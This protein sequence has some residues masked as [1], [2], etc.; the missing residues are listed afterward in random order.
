MEM[1]R[2]CI[3]MLNMWLEIKRGCRRKFTRI[4]QFPICSAI[5]DD[6]CHFEKPTL[7]KMVA[8]YKR[9]IKMLKDFI[10]RSFA[11]K[12]SSL[13]PDSPLLNTIDSDI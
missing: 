13:V 9:N 12:S 11:R 10:H 4:R 3:R 7:Q 1:Q 5:T 8:S 2:D 6:L